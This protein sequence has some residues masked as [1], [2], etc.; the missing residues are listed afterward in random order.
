[1]DEKGWRGMAM[2][3]RGGCQNRSNEAR[4]TSPDLAVEVP[5]MLSGDGLAEW[6]DGGLA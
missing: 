4:P 6:M 3:A 5:D 1:M 2:A